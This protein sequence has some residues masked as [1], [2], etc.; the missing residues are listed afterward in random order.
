MKP[1]RVHAVLLALLYLG[2]AQTTAWAQTLELTPFAGYET[3]SS[4]P[5]ENPTTVQALRA[6]GGRTYGTFVDY[7]I[8]S[9]FQA[10]FLWAHNPTTYSEQSAGTGQ[11]VPSFTSVIDQYQFG[12]CICCGRRRTRGDR[13]SPAV[14]VSRTTRTATAMRTTQRSGWAWAAAS[15]IG[16]RD[17]LASA[18]TPVCC[19]RME[20]RRSARRATGR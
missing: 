14:S 12:D 19:L 13:M 17:T 2:V 16:C 7:A 3:S 11:Y 8:T 5:L 9:D 18:L 4:Y 20:A 15:S 1:L 6:D 10:E